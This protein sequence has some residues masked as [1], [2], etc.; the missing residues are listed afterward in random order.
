MAI[1]EHDLQSFTGPILSDGTLISDL[2]D[3]E[4]KVASLR[5]FSDPEVYRAEQKWLFGR[6]WNIVA[7]ESE[8][9]N[10]GDYVMR[11]IAEDSVIVTRSRDGHISVMLNV[12]THRGMQ[13]CRAEAGNSSNFKCPYHGWVFGTEG[14]LIGA[15]FER[16]M[17]GTE[18]DKPNLG[19]RQAR[20]SLYAGIVFANWDPTAPPLEDFLGDF[21]FYLDTIFKRSKNG[22]VCVGAPQRFKINANW[23]IPSEQFCGADGYH[24]A[25]L[26]RTLIERFMPGA[27][28]AAIQE[29][30]RAVLFGVDVGSRLGHG[31][32]T[33]ARS[34]SLGVS[35]EAFDD[36][37]AGELTE[38]AIRSLIEEP[39]DGL[40]TELAGEVRAHLSD[41]QIRQLAT[42]PAI[43]GGIFP[44]NGFV[45]STIHSHNPL[46]HGAFE[47][48]HWVFVERDAPE[49]YK[50]AVA[51][52]LLLQFGTSGVIEQDDTEAWPSI[53]RAAS[54]YMGSQEKMRCQAFVG[55]NP[56]AGWPGGALVYDGFSK[57]DCHWN[58]WL[59]Y[60]DYMSGGPL[61][62][63][64]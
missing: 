6:S 31:V 25:T 22:L 9:P 12:C 28:A 26:H 54:G 18:L 53:Q 36:A 50:E 5:L 24:V 8:I 59:R 62:L 3:V 39:I 29:A 19:L 48:M 49:A 60:R 64:V 58:F 47:M 15:P 4:H 11:H 55:H 33:S 21:T 13:V 20:V 45:R 1:R 10:A 37:R 61:E 52:E 34:N 2:I 16:E 23:K 32:R 44:N 51:R 27:D 14:N 63:D 46:G 43:P 35:L 41:A 57:D 17:Y 40:P 7:H 42:Y 30:L 38:L 56:P